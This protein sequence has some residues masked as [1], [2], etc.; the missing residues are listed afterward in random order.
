M[1]PPLTLQVCKQG[2]VVQAPALAVA[3]DQEERATEMEAP[4]LAVTTEEEEPTAEMEA[5]PLVASSPAKTYCQGWFTWEGLMLMAQQKR[6]EGC[7]EAQVGC[8]KWNKSLMSLFIAFVQTL[9]QLR[10]ASSDLSDL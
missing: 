10:A 2:L 1:Q 9:P 8:T 6:D 4:V 5:K 3:S 7:S